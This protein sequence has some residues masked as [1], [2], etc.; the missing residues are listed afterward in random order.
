MVVDV[1][2]DGGMA[3]EMAGKADYEI[4]LMDVRMPGMGGTEATQLIRERYGLVDL[5][6]IAMTANAMPSQE[7]ECLAAGMSDFIG[8]PFDPSQLYA[9]IHKWVTGLGD[10][11]LLGTTG[12]ALRGANLHLPSSIEGLDVRAGLRRVAGMKA[13]YVK[14]LGGFADQQEDVVARIRQSVAN[15]DMER[16]SR[17]AHTLKGAAGMIEAREIYNLA[18]DLEHALTAGDLDPAEDL[19]DRLDPMLVKVVNAARAAIEG[20]GADETRHGAANRDTVTA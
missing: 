14:T 9:V 11:F 5:P 20:S 18:I 17:E 10:A 8:K 16:A 1:A 13:L 6:I 12:D 3:V 19:L 2:V 4:I 15:G 7:K